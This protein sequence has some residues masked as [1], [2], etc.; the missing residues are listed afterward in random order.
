LLANA[1]RVNPDAP[2]PRLRLSRFALKARFSHN[3]ATPREISYAR[4]E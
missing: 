2:Q 4:I 3:L 1:A